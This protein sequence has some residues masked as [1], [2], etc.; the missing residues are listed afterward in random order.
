MTFEEMIARQDL[1]AL[2]AWSTLLRGLELPQDATIEDAVAEMESR[3]FS[4]KEAMQWLAACNWDVGCFR[5]E[6]FRQ[7]REAEQREGAQ[8]AVLVVSVA[9]VAAVGLA[10]YVLWSGR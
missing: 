4:P 1:A 7:I 10:G 8:R 9:A 3:G 5:A 2:Q 6:M